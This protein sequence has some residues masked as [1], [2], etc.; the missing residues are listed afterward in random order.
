MKKV[1]LFA[2]AILLVFSATVRSQE[3]S[4]VGTSVGQ[5]LK[6]GVGARAA[7]LGEAYVALPGNPA[8]LYWNPAGIAAIDKLSLMISHATLYSGLGVTHSFLGLT[9]PLGAGNTIGVSVTYLS[10]DDIEITTVDYPQG[11]GTYYAARDY[12]VGVSFGR[13]VTDRLSLGVTLKFVREGIYRETAQTL[14]A[15]FG[16]VLN[17]GLLGIKL[18][19]CLSNFGGNMKL[20]GEDLRVSQDRYR[21]NPAEHEVNA[22]LTTEAWPL[23]MTFRMGISTDLVGTGGQLVN[24]ESNRLTLLIDTFDPNDALLR[25]NMGIEYEWNNILALR[26]GYHGLP[27]EKDNFK[28]YDTASYTFGGGLHYN[29]GWT[30]F[31]LD[32]A[33]TNFQILGDT[34]QFTLGLKF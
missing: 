11:T 2:L 10:T 1:A 8:A 31:Q 23:P 14:A 9:Y 34:H 25:S 4:R 7:A 32:Y 24:S 26:G 19:M 29:L 15:D 16:S 17:T 6:L 5:F 18:G 28:S 33:L 3:I 22:D 12:C 20:S 27:V 30:D 21:N 13:F